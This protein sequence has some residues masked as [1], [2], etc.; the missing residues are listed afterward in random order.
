MTTHR[1]AYIFPGQGSQTVGMGLDLY[2]NS[3]TARA[4]FEEADASLGFPLSQLCFSGPEDELSKTINAQ[5]AL[6]TA[7]FACLKAAQEA[8]VLPPPSFVAGHSLGEYAA[9]AV[10]GVFDY[11]TAIYLAKERGRL[12]QEA[13]TA[14]PGSMAAIIGMEEADL[15]KICDEAGVVIANINSP[16]QLVISGD[17]DRVAK[18]VAT[19]QQ[20]PKV[21]AIPLAVSAA[22]H[23]P[24]MQPA[25]A[26]MRQAFGKVVFKEAKIP[27]IANV[28]AEP[29][30]SPEAVKDELLK[31]ITGCVRWQKGIEKMSA[32]GVTLFVE[33]GAGKVLTGLVKRTLK[34]AVTLNIG[35]AASVSAPLA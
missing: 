25:E 7:S 5:P 33:L 19:A 14:R 28:T 21:K 18:A 24:L 12:M 17:R 13:G 16:G 34:G 32:S 35:D 1:V 8:G 3:A 9:L 15:Q 27:V 10:A 2:Q 30:T 22:F 29:V 6:A 11:G 23:S 20:V 4:V 26:G 31:Q